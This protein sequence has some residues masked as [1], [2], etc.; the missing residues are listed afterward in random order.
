MKRYII[1]IEIKALRRNLRC[2]SLEWEEY[3]R[4]GGFAK[5]R[6]PLP[7]DLG[8]IVAICRYRIVKTFETYIQYS[9][10]LVDETFLSTLLLSDGG[11][12]RYF[13]TL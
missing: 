5:N 1:P 13:R 4:V 11:W 10:I 7:V 12:H 9:L 8:R 3:L 6:L 2:F